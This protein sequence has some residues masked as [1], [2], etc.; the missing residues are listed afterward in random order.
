MSGELMIQGYLVDA[1]QECTDGT[2]GPHAFKI[3][4]EFIKGIAD[5]YVKLVRHPS[6]FIEVKYRRDVPS[7][8]I[9]D[10]L[11]PHQRHFLLDEQYAGGCAG[12][13]FVAGCKGKYLMHVTTRI[14][15][16]IRKL[17]FDKDLPQ[18][19]SKGIGEPWPIRRIVEIITG[20]IRP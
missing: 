16:P 18:V 8:P 2:S 12:L 17:S 20:V 13:V 3:R 1:A 19:L 4:N 9:L 15:D 5:L 11:T 7:R 6:A 14:E 10:G